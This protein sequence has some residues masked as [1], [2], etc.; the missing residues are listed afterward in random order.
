[1]DSKNYDFEFFLN[2]CKNKY[3]EAYEETKKKLLEENE[4]NKNIEIEEINKIKA[5]IEE[6]KEKI[7]KDIQEKN[8]K[9]CILEEE[10]KILYDKLYELNKNIIVEDMT[11]YE[12][13]IKI[14]NESFKDFNIKK[15]N[16]KKIKPLQFKFKN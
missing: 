16:K 3:I 11:H 4:K 12:Q 5:S 13:N 14:I 2:F 8:K 15:L 6:D 7:Y 10:K 9:I 1:M